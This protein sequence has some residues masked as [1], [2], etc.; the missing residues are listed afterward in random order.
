MQAASI[1][2]GRGYVEYELP[3]NAKVLN[4]AITAREFEMEMSS[5]VPGTNAD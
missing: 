4:Q 1:G 5:E 3:N 2:F